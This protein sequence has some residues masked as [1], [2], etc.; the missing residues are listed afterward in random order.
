MKMKLVIELKNPNSCGDCPLFIWD[1]HVQE[2]R[3]ALEYVYYN[4]KTGEY[5]NRD[6]CPLV[7]D[8]CCGGSCCKK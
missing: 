2:Y 1:D 4:H 5:V 6:K 7:P 8:T 3:C